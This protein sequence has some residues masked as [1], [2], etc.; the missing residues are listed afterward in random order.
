MGNIS[1][2]TMRPILLFLLTTATAIHNA[3][4]IPFETDVK[5]ARPPSWQPVMSFAIT[6]Q[7]PTIE[8]SFA[9]KQQNTSALFD[10]HAAVSDPASS[11][12]GHHLSNAAVAS[13]VAPASE[14][15]DAVKLFISNHSAEWRCATPNCDFIS[16]VVPISA[17]NTMLSAE[18]KEYLHESGVKAR[19]TNQYSLPDYLAPHVDF[20]APATRLPVIRSAVQRDSASDRH[21]L[22]GAGGNTPS[23]LRTLYSIGSVEGT[24]ATK[25]AATGFLGQYF[26][27]TD[28]EQFY[29]K[30]YKVASGRTITAKGDA[31]GSS[32]GVEASLDVDYISSV[33]GNVTTEFWSFDGHAPTNPQNEPFLKW[34]QLVSNTS[35]ADVPHVFST[36]Y[37]EDENSVSEDYA[38]RINVEFAKAGV[39][40]ISLMFASG[41][42][43]V[44]S[45]CKDGSFDSKWPA[46]SPYVTAVG[47]TAPGSSSGETTA[48]LSSGGFSN[49][50][51]QPEWQAQAV[52]EYLQSAG[53]PASTKYNASGRGFPDVSAQAVNF[54]VVN[55]GFV[56]PGVAGT[57]AAC[58]TFSAVVGLL[59]DFRVSSGKPTLGFLNPWIYTNMAAFNDVTTG[60]NPG[61]STEGFPAAKGWDPA[62]GVGTPNYAKMAKALP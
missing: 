12:Y 50:Y 25:Q 40:G 53:L 46:A 48:G 6:A 9:V 45:D 2:D 19:V 28:L 37:G 15:I 3:R 49:R 1:R 57:S 62:T 36:S 31:M 27:P 13:L 32:A 21:L 14:S 4:R 33:G 7:Q 51:K 5:A 54:V 47:G 34:M 35:D 55:N 11:Q 56:E 18:Y 44:G 17:A 24:G 26:K 22:G 38:N 23:S 43:G 41:D 29:S 59:N 58:P 10:L 30:Y 16:C 52:H 39:R 8:L 20:V 60:S 42:D 61:C